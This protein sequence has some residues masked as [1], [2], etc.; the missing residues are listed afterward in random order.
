MS[1]LLENPL[2]VVTIRTLIL[3][4]IV[5]VIMYIILRDSGIKYIFGSSLGILT[6][7]LGFHLIN[8]SL[9]KSLKFNETKAALLHRRDQIFRNLLYMLVIVLSIKIDSIDT[10]TTVLGLLAVRMVIQSDS[11]LNWFKLFYKKEV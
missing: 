7:L 8:L 10:F 2:K 1:K 4:L 3:T 6:S 5:D 9:K 11:V